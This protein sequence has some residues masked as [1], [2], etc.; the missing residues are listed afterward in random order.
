MSV[1]ARVLLAVAWS[2]SLVAVWQWSASA[3]VSVKVPGVEVRFQQGKSEGGVPTGVILANVKGQW[4]P[5][6]V[7]PAQ[8]G[9]ELIPLSRPRP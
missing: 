5:V 4:L 6:T 9:M 8:D 3:Q 2:L 7:K 1:R